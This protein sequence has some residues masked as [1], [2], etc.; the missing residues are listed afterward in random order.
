M[1]DECRCPGN[2]WV[3]VAVMSDPHYVMDERNR[4][5]LVTSMMMPIVAPCACVAERASI[6]VVPR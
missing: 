6:G 3:V 2:G 1:T 4:R 5:A